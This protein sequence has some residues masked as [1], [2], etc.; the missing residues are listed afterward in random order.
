MFK[1]D[2]KVVVHS[3]YERRIIAKGVIEEIKR[4]GWISVKITECQT[5]GF[6]GHSF[7]FRP[8]QLSIN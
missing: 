1:V 2:D 7:T 6:I 8:S 3:L 4:G 5:S